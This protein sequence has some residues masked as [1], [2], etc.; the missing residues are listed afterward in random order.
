MVL[1]IQ[2]LIRLMR[3]Y[4]FASA[5]RVPEQEPNG[6]AVYS[7]SVQRWP[8]YSLAIQIFFP[9]TAAAP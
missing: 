4:Q 1:G 8:M 3:V 6:A 7:A 5:V 2:G 9:S